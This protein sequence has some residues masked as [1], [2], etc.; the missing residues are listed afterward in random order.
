MYCLIVNGNP[1]ASG[2]DGY[3]EGFARGL[4]EKGHETKRIDLRDLE[5]RFCTGCW[6]CWWATPG[7][8]AIKDDMATVLPE[9]ARADLVVWASPLILGNMSALMKKAQDRCIPIAHPYSKL[10]KG[11]CHHRHRYARNAD[12]GL[13]IGPTGEDTEE[14]IGIAREFFRR[15]SLNTRTKFRLFATT[16]TPLKEALDAALDA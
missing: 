3:L 10:S 12:I 15:Y 5:L 9:I 4:E 14:D 6:S 8:C 11:E 7:L 13:I 1:E 16:A 2:F